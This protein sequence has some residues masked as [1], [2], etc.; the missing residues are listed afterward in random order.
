[1]VLVGGTV[2]YERGTPMLHLNSAV[3][4]TSAENYGLI[5]RGSHLVSKKV[6]PGQVL[7]EWLYTPQFDVWTLIDQG[8][9]SDRFLRP[10][11]FPVF[12]N[13]FR[14]HPIIPVKHECRRWSSNPSGE[15]S[16]ERPTRGTV[17]GTMRSMCGD[18]AGCLAIDYQSL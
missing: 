3:Q 10:W 5:L 1:M 6:C 4:I 15:C 17:C 9:H 2:S 14:A 18:D 13:G 7:P 8:P 16:Y 11:I 12:G